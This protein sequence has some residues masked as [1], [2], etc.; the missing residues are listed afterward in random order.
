M[1]KQPVYLEADAR[2]PDVETGG[3]ETLSGTNLQIQPRY[4]VC[5][6]SSSLLGLVP[7][8]T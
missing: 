3:K 2:N 7:A 1:E 6:I 4:L 8:T 5:V